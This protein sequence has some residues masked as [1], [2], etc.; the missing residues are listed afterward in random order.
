MV[1]SYHDPLDEI[2]DCYKR[3]FLALESPDWLKLDLSMAQLRVLYAIYRAGETSIGGVA[4]LLDIG[5]STTSHLV[6]RLVQAG[7]TQ[8]TEDANDRRRTLVSLTPSGIDLIGGMHQRAREQFRAWL[9]QLREDELAALQ[10]GLQALAQ[11]V[12]AER[13]SDGC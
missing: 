1:E 2:V 11:V 9:V 10:R 5:I 6:E 13:H 7:F 3:V 4:D 8:R 12:T